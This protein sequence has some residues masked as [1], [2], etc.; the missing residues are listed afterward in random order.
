MQIGVV[1]QPNVGKSTFFKALTLIEVETANYPFTT[2]EPNKGIGF[3]RID[4][5]DK[6]F[7]VQCN[8]RTGHCV[9]GQRFVP[10]ELID[11]AGLVPDAFKGKGLGNK[12]L[13][14]LSQA[15][16]LIQVIDV[17][18]R[19]DLEGK[20]C[21]ASFEVVEKAITF[22]ETEIDQWFN[23]I[24]EKNWSK[25]SK[26]KFESKAKKLEAM[27]QNLSGIGVKEEHLDKALMKLNLIETDLKDLS[28]EQRLQLAIKL[29]ELSK[30]IMIAA[31]KID[32][33]EAKENLK[34]LIEKFP[35]KRIFSCSAEAETALKKAAK[36]GLIEYMPGD[37]EFKIV[38]E[39]N[40]NQKKAL[41]LIKEKVLKEFNSTGVQAILN[42]IVLE[43]LK[44]IAIFPGGVNKL[45]DSQGNILP[46][47]F[48]MPPKTTALDF[49]FKLHT[50]FGKNFIKAID[51][52][53]KQLIGKD[54]ELK[55]RDVIEIVA[56]K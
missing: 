5:I 51:V 18:G 16:A 53:K 24:L 10:V 17:S 41:E 14:D 7:N 37:N 29:R 45:S 50:D 44:Y 6:E 48:L 36:T 47:C 26:Q 40:E 2:I 1:G 55:H 39:L 22:L 28:E 9:K 35:L 33:P 15:D 21:Q 43:E 42:K 11:V 12:F 25:F 30:P 32:L 46:D 4:C 8:P 27:T 54:H 49:A 34:K 13:S 23:Q 56:N 52:K 3:I 20:T 19:T 38:K 31:N